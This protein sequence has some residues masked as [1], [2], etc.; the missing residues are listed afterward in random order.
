MQHDVIKFGPAPER[1]PPFAV[2]A[3]HW[4]ACAT[5]LVIVRPPFALDDH[6]LLHAARIAVVA[7]TATA[8]AFALKAC[9]LSPSTALCS[10]VETLH[11]VA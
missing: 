8:A 10:A 6:G 1:V 11:R 7:S 9:G 5:L 2:L 4:V 3:L